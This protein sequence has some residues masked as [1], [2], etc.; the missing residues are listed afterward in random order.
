MHD[1]HALTDKIE[2]ELSRWA[3]LLSPILESELAPGWGHRC[4]N[5]PPRDRYWGSR[6]LLGGRVSFPRGRAP[7]QGDERG[8]NDGKGEGDYPT[9]AGCSR[10]GRVD[11]ARRDSWTGMHFLNSRC[12][13][14]APSRSA[15][16]VRVG[17]KSPPRLRSVAATRRHRGVSERAISFH[18]DAATFPRGCMQR[19]ERYEDRRPK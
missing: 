13:F 1:M 12:P 8:G 19:C 3:L 10:L 2:S 7:L 18:G 14:P 16:R 6:R 15:T 11:R 4:E 5:V 9:R 17:Q